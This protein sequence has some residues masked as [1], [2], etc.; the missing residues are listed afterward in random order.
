[1][2]LTLSTGAFYLYSE[3]LAN[4]VFSYGRA[5]QKE[6]ID[7]IVNGLEHVVQQKP[8][9]IQN[10]D[11]DPERKTKDKY[12]RRLAAKAAPKETAL[13]RIDIFLIL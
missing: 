7:Q 4:A 8:S 11:Q 9:E 5:S 1:M 6:N 10:V 13:V 2:I 3:D 12:V